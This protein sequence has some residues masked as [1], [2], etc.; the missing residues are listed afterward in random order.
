MIKVS[1]V[2]LQLFFPRRANNHRPKLLKPVAYAYLS[3]V[4]LLFV[5]GL[6]VF[7]TVAPRHGLILGFA[8]SITPQ[9]VIEMTNMQRSR[10]GLPELQHNPVL[11]AAAQSKAQHMMTHQYWAHVSPDGTEP[12]FFIKEAG[13]SYRVAGENL[14]RDFDETPR[15]ISAWMSS[16]THRANIM[17]SRYSEIGIAVIDGKLEGYET[18]LVVQLFGSPLADQ[19]SGDLIESGQITD[20]STSDQAPSNQAPAGVLAGVAQQRLQNDTAINFQGSPSPAVL[21]SALVPLGSID[22]PPLFTPVQ[23]IKAVFLSL[24]MLLG[25]TLLYDA[26]L[27][28]NNR[29]VRI[30]GKNM[31]H[32]LY[33]AAIAYLVIFFKA[34]LI[35]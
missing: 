34:G 12:W 20:S 11:S 23:L 25:A 28:Q 32:I 30:V 22:V 17:N 1:E 4:L 31:A 6:Q 3:A 13:Y 35:G 8:S 7:N 33:F 9:Q 29:T 18:T 5:V 27:A 2:L 24:I 16:P 21:S 26:W 19:L 15:M 14:A 10:A